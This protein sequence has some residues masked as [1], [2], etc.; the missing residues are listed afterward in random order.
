MAIE[1]ETQ[2]KY[3]KIWFKVKIVQN[4]TKTCVDSINEK[5]F[6]R[7]LFSIKSSLC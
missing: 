5:L 3:S 4:N 2:Q 6:A 1:F 7:K